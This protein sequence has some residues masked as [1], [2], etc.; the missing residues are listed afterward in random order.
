L[1]ESL[2]GIRVPGDPAEFDAALPPAAAEALAAFGGGGRYMEKVIAKARH[3]EVQVLGDCRDAVH[4]FEREC[5]LQR[6]RQKVW[7]EA[8]ARALS[9]KVRDELCQSAV[10]LTRTVGYSGAGTIEYLYDDEAD[11][12]YFIETNTRIQ[13]EHP[14]TEMITG[15]DFVAEML[16]IAGGKPLRLKKF[17]SMLYAG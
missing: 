3:I 8:P 1:V 15:I 13:V 9:P 6:R 10:R 16:H 12:F 2:R 17:E 5:S 11:R 4:C 7:D 14:V